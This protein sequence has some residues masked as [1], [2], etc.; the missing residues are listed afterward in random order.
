MKSDTDPQSNSL[1]E[2]SNYSQVRYFRKKKITP[3][4]L[5]KLNSL[6]QSVLTKAPTITNLPQISNKK[7]VNLI[8]KRSYSKKIPNEF[9]QP[10]LKRNFSSRQSR[11]CL[12]T[13]LKHKKLS[14]KSSKVNKILYSYC[15][16]NGIMK[17]VSYY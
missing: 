15:L 14:K 10:Y 6:S 5:L 4:L 12:E 11:N 13:P 9:A 1:I 3:D 2:D 8:K 16:E 7:K 17:F